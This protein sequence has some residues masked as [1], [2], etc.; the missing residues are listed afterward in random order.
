MTASTRAPSAPD[1]AP[2]GLGQPLLAGALTAVVGVTS[3]F[4]VVLAGLQAVGATPT[5]AASGLMV[6]CLVCGIGTFWLSRRHRMP[7]V[8]AWSTPGAAL[9]ASSSGVEGGWSAAVGAFVLVGMLVLLTA[10][11]PRLGE[12]IGMIP[13][14]VA[15]AMLAGVLLPLCL[16]AVTGLVDEPLL[17]LP[18]V[19]AW[20][21]SMA[22]FGR[23]ASPVAFLV[24]LVVMGVWIV[25]DGGLQGSLLPVVDVVAPTLSVQAVV[26]LAVPLYVVTMA[27]QNVPGVAVLGS[28]GFTAPWRPL[29]AVTGLGTVVGA[30]FG[31]H[32]INLAAITAAI[33]AGPEAGPDPSRRWWA[34]QSCGVTYL[35]LGVAST[36]IT[37]AATTAPVEVLLAVAGL[38]LMSTLAGAL[39]GAMAQERFRVPAV[40]T[41][42]VAASGITLLGI[43]AAFWALVVGLVVAAVTGAFRAPVDPAP[44]K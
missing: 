3:T 30:P 7:V 5:Q 19:L 31:G 29:M 39:T 42:V 34:G 11:W 6:L 37:V 12:L 14:P 27:S 9:L 43:G 8:L 24:A 40:T 17:V 13:T 32:A 44:P 15:Q 4:A 23:F 2:P 20:L 1:A 21:V 36:A 35:V 41:F 18:V 25:D 33:S 28:F 16:H 22:L 38:A 10:L 26:G